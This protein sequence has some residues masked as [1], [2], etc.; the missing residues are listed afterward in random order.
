MDLFGYEGDT[1]SPILMMQTQLFL[2]N[3]NGILLKNLKKGK[4]K[5]RVWN[6]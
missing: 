5:H 4:S 3:D 6:V 1:Q 2:A